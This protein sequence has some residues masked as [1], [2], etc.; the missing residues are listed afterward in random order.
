MLSIIA[1]KIFARYLHWSSD[2]KAREALA[3]PDP[4]VRQKGQSYYFWVW[5]TYI[6][7]FIAI[8]FAALIPLLWPIIVVG[9][10]CFLIFR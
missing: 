10:V 4:V 7:A 9:V 2:K 6:L 1:T 8:L 5:V 3:S